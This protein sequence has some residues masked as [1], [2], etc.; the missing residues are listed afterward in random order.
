MARKWS[1]YWGMLPAFVYSQ[2]Y[3]F[4]EGGR[5]GTLKR[6]KKGVTGK[7]IRDFNRNMFK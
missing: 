1:E 5:S 2:F 4:K 7:M 6:K 3:D